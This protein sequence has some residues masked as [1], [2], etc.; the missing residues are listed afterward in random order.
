MI[1]TNLART[2]LG[3]ERA[4]IVRADAVAWLAGPD[5]AA[6]APFDIVIVDP[7]Y[8]ET[9]LLLAALEAVGH[10]LAPP[11]PGSSPSTSGATPRRPASGC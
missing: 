9:A 1:A 3:G 5:A 7:P 8:A 2:R 6:A 4:R 10:R 11:A